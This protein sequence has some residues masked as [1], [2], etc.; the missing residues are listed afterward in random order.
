MG[1]GSQAAP[2][3]LSRRRFNRWLLAPAALLPGSAACVRTELRPPLAGA[4]SPAARDAGLVGLRHE[5]DGLPIHS[6]AP[7]APPPADAP[8]VVLVHG[9]ALSG[10]YMLPTAEQL[11]GRAMVRVPDLPGFGDSGKPDRVLDVPELADALAAWLRRVVARPATLLGN[12]FGCQI[13][14]DLAARHPELVHAAVLQGPTTPPGER[15][16]LQQFIRWR[17]N[18]KFNPPEL[19]DIAWAA[20]EKCGIPR[21]LITFH[22]SLVDPV[23]DKLPSVRAPTLVIRGEKDPICRQEWAEKVTRLLPRGELTVIPD[24]A[25]TLCYTSPVPLAGA[26]LDFLSRLEA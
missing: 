17:Q 21:A 2:G 10:R 19:G 7:A 12:S 13:I 6:L 25:H 1:N 18:A 8:L 5:V 22:Y 24:V 26:A 3:H 9:L 4:T 23:E 20:Y 11:V 14:V 15:T 16:W